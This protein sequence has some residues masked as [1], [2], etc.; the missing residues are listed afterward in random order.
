MAQ[1]G[2]KSMVETHIMETFKNMIETCFFYL[3][4]SEFCPD[5]I[6]TVTFELNMNGNQ[7]FSKND[8]TK[9]AQ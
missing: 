3:I 7:L 1:L 2:K 9:M 5:F 6:P 8:M 4:C